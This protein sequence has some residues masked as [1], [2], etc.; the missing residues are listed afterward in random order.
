MLIYCTHFL[1]ILHSHVIPSFRFGFQ[2]VGMVA[3][4]AAFE[5]LGKAGQP[6]MESYWTALQQSW[7]WQELKS[8]H[9]VRPV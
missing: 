1:Y 6:S 4:E 2:V 5:A 3:A 8:V 7:V 9:N